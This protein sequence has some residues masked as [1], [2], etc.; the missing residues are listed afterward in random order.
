MDSEK[1][2]RRD[3]QP[4]ALLSVVALLASRLQL[5]C[6]LCCEDAKPIVRYVRTRVLVDRESVRAAGS[7]IQGWQGRWGAGVAGR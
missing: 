5:L 4:V 1:R 3:V 6:S 2:T 7:D